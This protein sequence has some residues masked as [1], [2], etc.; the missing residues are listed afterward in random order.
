[1]AASRGG[2]EESEEVMGDHRVKN[3][4][5]ASHLFKP[6]EP[7]AAAVECDDVSGAGPI[8]LYLIVSRLPHAADMVMIFAFLSAGEE[9][10]PTARLVANWGLLNLQMVGDDFVVIDLG[11]RFGAPSEVTERAVALKAVVPVQ[12]VIAPHLVIDRAEVEHG[13]AEKRG[14]I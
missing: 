8:G 1:M 9:H 11:E 10:A 12:N 7:R 4:V 3:I 13:L 6:G 14:A 2:G 5:D